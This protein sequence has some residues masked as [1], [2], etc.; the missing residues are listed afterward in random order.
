MSEMRASQP[1]GLRVLNRTGAALRKLGVPLVRLD[2]D[3]LLQSARKSASLTDFGHDSFRAPLERLVAS[4]ESEA[5][6]TLLGRV[7]ARRDLLRLLENRLRQVD[8]RKQHREINWERIERPL[9]ILGLPRTGTSILHELMAQDPAN[10]VPMTWEV[11]HPFPPP[12]TRTFHS[13][14]R[15]A[16]VDAHFSGIDRLLPDFK[17]MHP[18]GARLPQECVVITQH[19]FASMVWHTSNR[20][21]SY[22]NW[23]DG[24]DLRHVYESHK[25]WLQVLQWKAPAER[26]V[27]KSPGHLWALE[28][29]LAVY[30]DARIVQNHRDPL[31]VVASLVSLV[32][33][34]RSLATEVI[35][36]HEIG[37]DWTQRLAAG[38]DHATRVRDE[39][40]LPESQVFDVPFRAFMADEIAM[41]RKIY[42][43]FGMQYTAE[44]ERR[45][46]A[47]LA[48]N[49]ADKHGRHTYD[50]SLGGLDE[51][52]ERKRYAAYQQRF[53]IPSE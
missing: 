8:L 6:L 37:R 30:P 31:K 11:M 41:V 43:H 42:E 10:R 50:L 21:P 28:S 47:F 52:T 22:Q 4:L 9:F 35:D 26:W 49:A 1:F 3:S 19:E 38:L 27:L 20:V 24:A 32:C 18:M 46:R 23:L 34:L 7:I 16:Q 44:A 15:I 51:A 5:Q 14:P 48:A 29:L 2:A 36:P 33:T 39:A 25:R 53:A 40:K 12:E 17:T 45:M 13:D